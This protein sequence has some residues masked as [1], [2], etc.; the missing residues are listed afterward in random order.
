MTIKLYGIPA[1]R[2]M[3]VL[4]ALHEVG[5]KFEHDPISYADPALKTKAYTDI[6]PNGKVPFLV[7][8]GHV[9][10][11][12]LAI[13]TYLAE[14]YP[15]DISPRTPEERGGVVQWATWVLTECEQHSFNWYL[16]TS[17]KPQAERD[18]AV[19]ASAQAALAAAFAVLEST[20]LKTPFLLGDRFTVADL[21]VACTLYRSLW[22][23]LSAAPTMA[24]W[25]NTCFA[26]DGGRVARRA[27][28]EIV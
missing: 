1:S 21:N 26:R 11:E 5:Q 12:S 17:G 15:C 10:F 24:K 27:R 19:A 18:P 20:L 3:R 16:N 23:D 22:M 2:T 4:W 28:G 7:D 13:T 8:N 9:V 6:N 14:K 25:L